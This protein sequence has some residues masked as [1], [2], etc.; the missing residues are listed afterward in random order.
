MNPL[1]G[2]WRVSER[3]IFCGTLRI[4]TF[5]FDT[6]PGEEFKIDVYEQMQSAL[7]EHLYNWATPEGEERE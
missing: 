1:P 5:C 7:N 2:E 4:A 6:D 3:G